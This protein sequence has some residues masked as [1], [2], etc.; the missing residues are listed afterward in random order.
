MSNPFDLDDAQLGEHLR[1][2]G[3]HLDLGPDAGAGG[4]VDAVLGA[5]PE[6]PP[7]AP[8][9]ERRPASW[10]LVA[11]AIVLVV[12]LAVAVVAPAR[13]AVAR[14][15]GI[16]SVRIE[17]TDDPAPT[18]PTSTSALPP[19]PMLPDGALD[20]EAVAERLPFPVRLPAAEAAG[21]PTGAAVDPAV[22]AG[23]MAV[24]YPGFTFVA[25]GSQ[26]GS[27]PVLWKTLGPGT[28]SEPV[29]IGG[30]EGLWITGDPHE[31]AFVD[32]DG[33]PQRDRVRGAGDVLVWEADGVTYRI[34][35]APSLDEALAIAATVG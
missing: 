15:L 35:G 5:L 17:R 24:R 10:L 6:G 14:W 16:G 2:L 19:A 31:V 32:P 28:E 3:R 20:L 29:V 25:V 33:N 12:G 7:T 22:P 4:L 13:E 21:E 1:D 27:T 30:D 11:A 26:P 9:Q 8:A 23:L 34:E 18:P